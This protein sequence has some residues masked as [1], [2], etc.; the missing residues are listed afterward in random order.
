M[1]SLRSRPVLAILGAAVV[2]T[3]PHLLS[4]GGQENLGERFAYLAIPFGFAL[5]AGVLGVALRS[6]WAA[7]GIHGGL[8]VANTPVSELGLSV[9]GPAQ[10]ILIG[11]LFTLV[12]V[13]I[14]LQLPRERWAEVRDRGPY[15]RALA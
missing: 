8:H 4:Q 14:G 5:T 7:I 13:L 15:A 3:I 10:W 11:A 12:A 2:F 1:Q 6:V 9:D